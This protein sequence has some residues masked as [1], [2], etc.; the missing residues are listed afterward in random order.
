MAVEPEFPDPRGTGESV[1]ARE[2]ARRA[3]LDLV[4]SEANEGAT[5]IVYALL[6]VADAMRERPRP[7]VVVPLLGDADPEALENVLDEF[8]KVLS[9]AGYPPEPA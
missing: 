7:I 1:T 9:D 4:P 8:R 3:L 6:D 5:P 2:A